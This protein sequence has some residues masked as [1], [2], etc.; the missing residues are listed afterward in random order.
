MN[1]ALVIALIALAGSVFSTAITV[2]GAPAFQARRDAKKALD[3]YREPLLAASYELQ[4]RLYNILQ[5]RFVEKYINDDTAGKRVSAIE[6][7]LYVFAQ[8]FGWREIIRREVQYLRFSRDAQTR[9]IGRLLRNIGETFLSDKYGP[10][11]MIWRVE[12]RGLGERMIISADSKLTC[13]G[14]ASFID[15]RATMK[16]W[17]QP[18]ESDFEH[19]QD[20]G[21]KRLI[22][23][24]YLLLELVKQLDDKQ[25]RYPFEMNKAG[26][27][28]NGRQI[29]S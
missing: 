26:P 14:Y 27:P 5:L 22:E 8:F 23:L 16:E 9:E 1:T 6:S 4:A 12:Q 3:S 19:L 15:Q 29:H 10:Q 25:K 2:F 11:F 17:L 13:L 24:Q 20:E 18:L 7:T 28:S 21:R